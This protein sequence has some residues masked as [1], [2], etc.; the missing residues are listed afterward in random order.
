VRP[1]LRRLTAR[2]QEVVGPLA[3][4]LSNAEIAE[5][6]LISEDTLKAHLATIRMK[7]GG[8]SRSGLKA[9]LERYKVSH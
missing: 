8:I 9:V 6:L 1:Y 4:G 7:F 5:R 3:E 2:E